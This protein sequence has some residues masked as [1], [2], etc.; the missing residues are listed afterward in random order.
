MVYDALGMIQWSRCLPGACDVVA[1]QLGNRYVVRSRRAASAGAAIRS[2]PRSE[3]RQAKRYGCWKIT[4]TSCCRL[5]SAPRLWE[6]GTVALV[7]TRAIVVSHSSHMGSAT[8]I[9]VQS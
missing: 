3:T 7:V 8:V 6:A 2:A 1:E 5:T 4:V 9:D